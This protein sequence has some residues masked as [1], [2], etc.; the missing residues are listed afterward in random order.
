MPNFY[1]DD[2][3]REGEPYLVHRH[4]CLFRTR[5]ALLLGDFSWLS[6]AIEAAKK[7]KDK[8]ARC[9]LC[10]PSP[11]LKRKKRK[12]KIARRAE[13]LRRQYRADLPSG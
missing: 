3:C 10:G 12:S 2:K 1:L 5:K 13:K 11:P 4:F 7:Q 9:E 6:E 8:I